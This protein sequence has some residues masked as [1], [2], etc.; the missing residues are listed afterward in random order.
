ME[1]QALLSDKIV[2]QPFQYYE[3]YSYNGDFSSQLFNRRYERK[4][5]KHKYNT[6]SHTLFVY[7]SLFS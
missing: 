2:K 4:T 5:S 6:S 3:L 7:C 1:Y